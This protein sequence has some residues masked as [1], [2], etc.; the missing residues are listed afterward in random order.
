MD[1]CAACHGEADYTVRLCNKCMDKLNIKVVATDE[2]LCT[3]C[4]RQCRDASKKI[5]KCTAFVRKEP[6]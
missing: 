5:F 1:K 6:Q 3:L 2:R 4:A